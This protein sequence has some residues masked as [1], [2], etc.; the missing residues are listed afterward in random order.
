MEPSLEDGC[1]DRRR[2]DHTDEVVVEEL[3][4]VHRVVLLRHRAVNFQEAQRD[5]AQS[6]LLE[7]REDLEGDPSLE[8]VRFEDDERPFGAHDAMTAGISSA[9]GGAIAASAARGP[10]AAT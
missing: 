7:T 1:H 9:A 8:R 2:R 10:I 5:Q 4:L 6:A 3:F